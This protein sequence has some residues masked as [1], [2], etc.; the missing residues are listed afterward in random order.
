MKIAVVMDAAVMGERRAIVYALARRQA[1]PNQRRLGRVIEGIR[2]GAVA[3]RV[4]DV[5]GIDL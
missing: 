5:G 1:G 3:E 4:C 2:P